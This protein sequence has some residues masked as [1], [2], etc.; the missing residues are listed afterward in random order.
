[1]SDAICSVGENKP[2]SANWKK[3]IDEDFMF[4]IEFIMNGCTSGQA[5]ANESRT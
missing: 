4:F 3:K 5:P 1:M 2:L